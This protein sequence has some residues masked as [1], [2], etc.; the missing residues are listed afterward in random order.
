MFRTLRD[1][2]AFMG[3]IHST[4]F[5]PLY[6]ALQYWNRKSELSADRCGMIITS[7]E[8]YQSSLVKLASGLKETPGMSRCLI[9]QGKQY[10]AFKHSSLWSRIQQEYRCVFYSHP[11]LCTRAMEVDRWRNSHTYRTLRTAI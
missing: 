8:V 4:L 9:E 2:G 10:E 11:Q 1:M 7:E 5:A 3:L 6:L